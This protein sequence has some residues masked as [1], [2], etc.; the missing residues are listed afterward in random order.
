MVARPPRDH[1]RQQRQ[2]PHAVAARHLHDRGVRLELRK[3][4][5]RGRARRGGRGRNAELRV[6]H[7][8]SRR[9]PN[10]L[11]FIVTPDSTK[12]KQNANTGG[13]DMTWQIREAGGGQVATTSTQAAK[14]PGANPEAH[15]KG[16]ADPGR[17]PA[18]HRPHRATSSARGL[19][20]GS[21]WPGASA[22]RATS[23]SPTPTNDRN[24]EF[25]V[26]GSPT[27]RNWTTP[28]TGD[29]PGDM[30]TSNNCMAQVNVGGDNG[31]YCWNLDTGAGLPR[32]R[33][34]SRGRGSPA[35]TAYRPDDNCSTSAA[36]TRES[37][38]TSGAG[39]PARA[40]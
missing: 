6:A 27:G 33:V 23:G 4:V 28:W 30:D 5:R 18:G 21:A 37:S 39:V 10:A 26:T 17:R 12:T 11:E 29:W 8:S 24:T 38:T 31:I 1:D 14:A 20:A 36:G 22:T 35:R 25:S 13:L 2:L 40:R 16:L 15:D 34:R 32:S 7:G 19:R 3:P 9:R